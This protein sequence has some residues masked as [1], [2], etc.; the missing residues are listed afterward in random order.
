MI[1]KYDEYSEEK[2]KRALYFFARFRLGE[3]YNYLS[4]DTIEEIVNAMDQEKREGIKHS[5]K[6]I[7]KPTIRKRV[8][9]INTKNG[10]RDDPFTFEDVDK[11]IVKI[12]LIITECSEAIEAVREDDFENFKE[13]LADIRIR[14]DDLADILNISLDREVHKKLDKL[15]KREFRHGG[16]RV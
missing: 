10:W 4:D 7:R 9:D 12:A 6:R 3:A 15:E 5:Y 8:R 13:E 11:V 1:E 14:T 16:K 2:R